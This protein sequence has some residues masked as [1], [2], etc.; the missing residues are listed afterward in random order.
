MHPAGGA[1]THRVP[2]LRRPPS[3]LLGASAPIFAVRQRYFSIARYRLNEAADSKALSWQHI[4]RMDVSGGR[5]SNFFRGL[6]IGLLVGVVGGAIFGATTASG[7]DGYNAGPMAVMG[8]L[9]F[10]AVGGIA[11]GVIGLVARSENWIPVS[12][13]HAAQKNP[14]NR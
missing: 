2:A 1:G 8:G 14:S 7:V 6:G 3:L 9:Y 4:S 5:H 13:P 10:G 11:G 12:L